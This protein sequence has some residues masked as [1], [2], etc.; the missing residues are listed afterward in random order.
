MRFRHLFLLLVL[1]VGGAC[2]GTPPALPVTSPTGDL[3]RTRTELQQRLDDYERLLA[4]SEL[5]EEE[6]GR[7]TLEASTIRQRLQYGDF[8][9]GDRIL[10]SVEGEEETLPD[11]VL[12]EPGQ[13]V[14]LP[15]IGVVPV[16][17]VLRSEI[18]EHFTEE[19][20]AF[21]VEPEVRASGL[22]RVAI[23]GSVGQPGFYTMPAEMVLGDAIMAAGGPSQTANVDQVRIR[24][25]GEQIMDGGQTRIALQQGFTLDQLNIQ[26]GDQINVP[27]TRGALRLLSIITGVLGSVTF[28]LWRIT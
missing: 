27:Q 9:V 1:A 14:D 26:G 22:V 15:L 3:V 24:R 16:G 28:I 2:S 7:M 20:S 18:S 13:V 5:D 17:G 10:L 11:T 23:L 25:G 8:R 6:R 4:S 19:L 21:F 12:V